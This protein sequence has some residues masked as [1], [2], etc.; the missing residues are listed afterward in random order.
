[1]FRERET[2]TE[3]ETRK[4][5]SDSEMGQMDSGRRWISWDVTMCGMRSTIGGSERAETTYP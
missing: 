4:V 3:R 1:M 5:S 2:K